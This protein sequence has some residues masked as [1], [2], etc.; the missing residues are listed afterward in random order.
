MTG[1]LR[2]SVFF[3]LAA[4]T[5]ALSGCAGKG[6]AAPTAQ[7][8]QLVLVTAAGWD[9]RAGVLRRFERDASGDP[10]R[11]VGGPVTVNLGRG[12][13]GWGLGLHG[14]AL[15]P[16]P[17]KREGDGR[18]PVGLFAL[19][20]GFAYDPAAAGPARIPLLRAD[21]D[22][23]CVDDGASRQ[24]NRIV[25]ASAVERDWNSA[26]DM[27]RPDGQYRYGV[28]VRHNVAPET[29]GQGSC[30]FLHVWLGR[31]VASSGCTNMD[32]PDMLALLRWLDAARSPLLAQLPQAEYERLRAAWNLPELPPKK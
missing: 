2:N 25:R 8:R 1:V 13:L 6:P 21:A 16:G 23:V 5:L 7:S 32:A 14:G 3:L 11:P 29:P 10:W 4:L 18:A 19:G 28:F 20:E 9:S 17:V 27:L 31:G 26:E 24:Y 22:L 12:G 30:I 15:G